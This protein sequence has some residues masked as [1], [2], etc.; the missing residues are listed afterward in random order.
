[1]LAKQAL[2]P[3]SYTFSPVCSGYFGNEG[4]SNYFHGLASNLDLPDLSLPRF[5]G[6]KNNLSWAPVAHTCNPSYSGD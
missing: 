6:F 1:M 3:L 2:Y 5:A 4:L